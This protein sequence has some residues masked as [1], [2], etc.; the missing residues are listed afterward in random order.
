MSHAASPTRQIGLDTP[1]DA[2]S[3]RL[4]A[5]IADILACS[6]RG[7]LG[8]AF[9]LIELLRALYDGFLRYDPARP[10]WDGRDRFILS[11]G[12]GCLAQYVFLAEK[13]F[14]DA[15]DL[16]LFCRAE[17]IL[18]GHPE[19]AK[20]PGVECSTGSLGHGLPIG[21]GM[22][23]A[24]RLR[25]QAHRVVVVLGDGECDEGTVWE[26]ALGAGNRGLSNLLVCVDYNKMQSYGRTAA[27]ADLEPLAAKWRAFGFASRE[28]DGHDL[29]ALGRALS[30]FPFAPDRPSCLICH[31]V[32]G[33]G[34]ALAENNLDWHHKSSLTDADLAAIRQGL[35]CPGGE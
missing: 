31:T 12:H 9:S 17:G 24:A 1:L 11:K 13:G 34:L 15:A 32:K 28:V 26:A 8:S 20:I 16:R 19:A 10:D 22:A 18:G 23:L 4:R 14:I 35:A 5:R 21:V 3:R 6:R 29:A 33:K 2:T 7:H 25:G 30:A 27:V